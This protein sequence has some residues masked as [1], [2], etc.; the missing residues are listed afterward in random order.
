M[1]GRQLWCQYPNATA[2]RDAAGCGGPNQ[3]HA[4]L[5]GDSDGIRK[6]GQLMLGDSLHQL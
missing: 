1:A 5:H 4:P 2:Q 3:P 6:E